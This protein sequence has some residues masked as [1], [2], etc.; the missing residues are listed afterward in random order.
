MSEAKM[1]S[2]EM[3]GMM[4]MSVVPKFRAQLYSV[5]D[6]VGWHDRKELVLS[7]G[8]QRRKVWNLQGKSYL[9]DSI[10]KGMPMPQFFIR[11]VVHP[12]ERRI[13]REV[14]DGQQRITAILDFIDGK[15]TVLP[16]HNSS[17]AKVKYGALPES[18]QRSIL[19]Y[20]LSVN[21]LF[22]GSDAEVL[23]IFARINSYSVTL[24][25]PEKLN[26]KYTGAFREAM[27][28]MARRH[29]M[30]W[31]QHKIFGEQQ[32]ARMRDVDLTADLVS[33]MM[34]DL[35]S[36][37]NHIETQYKKYDDEFP[38]EDVIAA[39]FDHVLSQI[40]KIV[41]VDIEETEFRRATLFYS[42][43]TAVYDTAFGFGC[44]S[45]RP[46][47][48]LDDKRLTEI[49]TQLQDISDKLAERETE[50]AIGEM[51]NMLRGQTTNLQGR[52]S[53]H[54]FLKNIVGGAFV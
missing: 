8:F 36:G 10:V 44:T 54:D 39:Q 21:V 48:A 2:D 37:K 33:T 26:A 19:S 47:K 32:I 52:R 11:E 18:T 24:N 51:V 29:L 31:R 22:A 25:A 43:F 15:F 40:E 12:R 34:T 9:I 45:S 38:Q 7:P 20:T 23:D 35:Q 27:N 49:N 4:E 5:S 6:I 28:R 3:D 14:V 41:G 1:V 50:G 30:Y 13:I 42:L 17:I 46:V 53:R 16:S